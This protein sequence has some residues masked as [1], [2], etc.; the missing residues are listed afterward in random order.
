M[1]GGVWWGRMARASAGLAICML[2]LAVEIAPTASAD[3]PTL[4]VTNLGQAAAPTEV[5][6]PPL[7]VSSRGGC[8][9]PFTL[10]DEAACPAGVWPPLGS[11][12]WDTSRDRWSPSEHVA[13]GDTLQLLFSSPVASVV[14]GSTSNYEPGLHDPDG[15][16]ISNYDVIPESSA[17]PTADAAT[18]RVTLP[19]FDYRALNGYTFSVVGGDSSGFHDYALE[20]RSPRFADENERCGMAYFSTGVQQALCFGAF[21]GSYPPGHKV[22]KRK[23]CKKGFK[24]KK[25]RGKSRCVRVKKPHRKPHSR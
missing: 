8:A 22:Q 6:Q 19:A 20:I 15:K 16:A 18:W 21:P 25:V 4:T 11:P 3:A 9:H 13:G 14:V 23:K 2:A 17:T 5:P 1:S 24:R 12:T 10:A 7:G